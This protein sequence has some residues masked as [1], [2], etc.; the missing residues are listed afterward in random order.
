MLTALLPRLT[1]SFS[2][3]SMLGGDATKKKQTHGGLAAF[4]FF[5]FLENFSYRCSSI[6]PIRPAVA[7]LFSNDTAAS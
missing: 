6:A 4:E 2:L 3:L 1:A 5:D 7:N